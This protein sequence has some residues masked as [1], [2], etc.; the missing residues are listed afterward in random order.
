MDATYD[1]LPNNSALVDFIKI[2]H[3]E[4]RNGKIS[5]KYFAFILS[6]AKNNIPDL[7]D[8]GPAKE[9]DQTILDFRKK[10]YD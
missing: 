8:L 1:S 6:S 7:V 3:N 9:I 5:Q 4:F 2:N 10:L